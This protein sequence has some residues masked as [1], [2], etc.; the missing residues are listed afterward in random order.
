MSRPPPFTVVR[1]PVLSMLL[2][3]ERRRLAF[4]VEQHPD[5]WRDLMRDALLDGRTSGT[6]IQLMRALVYG[7]DRAPLAESVDETLA[8]LRRP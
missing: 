1:R 3:D 2:S 5:C 6:L 8:Q 4:F 7:D